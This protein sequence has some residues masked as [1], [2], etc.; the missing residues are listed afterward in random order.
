MQGHHLILAHRGVTG[1]VV[2]R[3]KDRGTVLTFV[4]TISE[5]IQFHSSF[6]KAAETWRDLLGHTEVGNGGI[7]GVEGLVTGED[8]PGD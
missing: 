8:R 1:I 2:S 5:V 6:E 4:E 7:V 3:E